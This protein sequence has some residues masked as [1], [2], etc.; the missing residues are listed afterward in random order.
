MATSTLERELTLTP[1]AGLPLFQFSLDNPKHSSVGTITL[2]PVA[3]VIPIEKV[4]RIPVEAPPKPKTQFA[5]LVRLNYLAATKNAAPI[6]DGVY[7]PYRASAIQIPG[8]LPHPTQL[9]ESIAMAAIDAPMPTFQPL[10]PADILFKNLASHEQLEALIYACDAH[11]KHFDTPWYINDK[12]VLAVARVDNLA[13]KYHR[14]GFFIGD[15]TGVGKGREAS[16]V[17]LA[18]WCEGRKRAIWVSK[19][20]ILVE[21]ARRDWE[22]LGGNPEQVV[23]L[24]KFN[25]GQPV[26]LTEGILFV[27]YGQLSTPAKGSKKSR[28][29]QICD[30]AG[31][32][33]DGVIAFDESHLLGNCINEKGERGIQKASKRGVAGVNIVDRLWDAR[34]V[35][36]S[37]TGAAKV[38]SLSYCTRLGLWMTKAFPFTSR[39]DFIS[40]MQDAGLAAME[41]VS[42]DFKRLGLYL[43]RTLSFEGVKFET[44]THELTAAQLEIWDTYAEAFRHVHHQIDEVSQTIN[45]TSE[46]GECTNGR[47]KAGVIGAFESTK[48]R[49]FAALLC[50]MKAPTLIASIERDIEA[51]HACVIQLVSTGAALMDRKLANIPTSDWNDMRAVDFT[52]RDGICDYLMN[53]FPIHLYQIFQD[54]NGNERSELMKDLDGNQIISQEAISMRDDLIAR[55]SMLPPVNGLLDQIN[56]HF[57][58]DRVA[59][60]TGR[61]K[62]VVFKD[63]RYQLS[64]RSA[65][66]NTAETTAFQSD[67]KQILVFSAAGGTGRSYHASLSCENQ[68]LRRHYMVETGWEAIGATQAIGR[69]HRS[70]QRQ[71]PEVVL[72]TTDVKGEARFTSTIASRLGTLGAISKGQ[73]NTGS[74]GLFSDVID[75]SSIYAQTALTDFFSDLARHGIDGISSREFQDYTGLRLQNSDGSYREQLPKMNTFLNRLLALKIDLQNCLFANLEKRI[76]QRISEAKAS[77]SYDLG[78]QTIQCNGGFKL[79]ESQLLSKHSSGSETICHSIDKRVKPHII[80]VDRGKKAAL[81]EGFAY[82]RNGSRLAVAHVIDQRSSVDGTVTDIMGLYHPVHDGTV[83]KMPRRAFEKHWVIA[84]PNDFFWRQ[85]QKEID[86][87]PEY[88]IERLYLICGLLLPIWEQ[89]PDENPEVFRLQTTDGQTLLGRAVSKNAINKLYEDFGIN[90]IKLEPVDILNLVWELGEVGTVGQWTIQ[91]KTYKGE[92]RIEVL[93]VDGKDKMEWLKS[94]GCFT[95]MITPEWKT[96]VFIP[97]DNALAVITELMPV[98]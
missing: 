56:W 38:S 70:A 44:V 33:F 96:R 71:P 8:A 5:E 40:S 4:I 15:S 83:N 14:C 68:R 25:L 73:R 20:E 35:Y 42:Q 89:L 65:N 64:Q 52:P 53:S 91:K 97:I 19:S 61:S 11:N 58:S 22:A 30:W 85:W 45:L 94:F 92:D 26:T 50:A 48:Q 13:A 86:D 10:L 95:E 31:E 23:P 60:V 36:L 69:S 12:G 34:V 93:N 76:N 29:D 87:A 62:R 55:I 2:A 81:K 46:K 9:A 77:G 17:I 63:E 1:F 39:E 16:L 43:A 90:S 7:T 72:L 74:Q 59:E 78:V 28:V 51:G 75:F 27:T 98:L 41:V 18:N 88:N 57:G 3:K 80:T 24:S 66:S 21:D 37:A 84:D 67:E 54:E 47:A 79:I 32:N 49:L 82:Y 6:S